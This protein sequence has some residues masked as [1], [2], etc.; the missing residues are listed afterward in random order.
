LP[1]QTLH[2]GEQLLCAPVLERGALLG[3]PRGVCGLHVSDCEGLLIGHYLL[4]SRAASGS[5]RSSLVICQILRA[6]SMLDQGATRHGRA[7]QQPEFTDP[8]DER[9]RWYPPSQPN[10]RLGVSIV[11]LLASAGVVI[12]YLVAPSDSMRSAALGALTICGMSLLHIGM[13]VYRT[14]CVRR[15]APRNSYVANPGA[16]RPNPNAAPPPVR[17]GE[18]VA[19]IAIGG[20]LVH[21]YGSY[22]QPFLPYPPQQSM[23]PPQTGGMG[24]GGMMPVVP[25]AVHNPYPAAANPWQ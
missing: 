18:P 5:R 20:A 13:L 23:Q 9:Q 24:G 12:S 2:V 15:E 1:L 17:H 7:V 8:G 19:Q 21:D 4:E 16:Y 14:R 3:E 22:Q 6:M 10:C 25:P 11:A